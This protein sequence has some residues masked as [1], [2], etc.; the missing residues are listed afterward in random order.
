MKDTKMSSRK[1]TGKAPQKIAKQVQ[2]FI[3]D[4]V[5][6]AGAK[7]AVLGISGGVD[8]AVVATLAT[9]ALG[10]DRV[11]ALIMP[12]GV[13]KPEDTE[14]AIRLANGL[15][16]GSKMI[17][18]KPLI[19]AFRTV[20][21]VE[22]RPLGNLMARVRM[23]LLYYYANQR[24]LLVL[25]TGNKTEISVGY[26][27]KWGDAACDLL[28]IGDLYKT[29]VRQLARYLKVPQ[30]ILEKAPT[31]GLWPGQTDEGEMGITYDELDAM[32]QSGKLNKRVKAMVDAS[33][34]KRDGPAVCKMKG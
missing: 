29:E 24:N 5:E 18:L 9:K 26:S 27:T 22:Q 28:P 23:T 11:F 16:I 4:K 13:T 34:H 15:G 1:G 25:G 21:K 2:E 10:K 7:G 30:R 14:D 33:A 20:L 6:A 32:L 3:A 19:D 31:A 12:A 8:S 17:A